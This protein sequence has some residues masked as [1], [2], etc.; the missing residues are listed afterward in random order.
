VKIKIEK[1]VLTSL[2]F[3]SIYV[4]LII[5]MSWDEIIH[6]NNGRNLIRYILSFGKLEYKSLGLPFHFGFYDAFSHFISL[7]FPGKFTIYSHH[8]TNLIFSI[9]AIYGITQFTK[10]LFN[11]EISKIVFLL[12]FFNPIFFG[13]MSVNPKDTIV[14]FSTIWSSVLILKYIKYQHINLKR[15][16][17]MYLIAITLFI[18]VGVR[19]TFI[20]TLLPIIFILLY[21]ITLNKRNNK[22]FNLKILL[23]DL[24]KV[25]L[26]TYIVTIIFWPEMHNNFLKPQEIIVEYFDQLKDGN[27]GLYWGLLNGQIINLSNTPSNY[28]FINFF[29]KMPEFFVISVPLLFIILLFD[30]NF[31]IKKIDNFKKN[32]LYLLLFIVFPI[33]LFI[34]L[35]I[36]VT[37]GL[38]FFLFLVPFLSI[39]PA[40]V[41]YYLF[42]KKNFIS[43][44]LFTSFS[45]LF[46]F[47][48]LIFF[49]IS[50]YQYTYINSLNGK[51]SSNINKFENDY[52][53]LSLKQLIYDF[54][55]KYPIKKDKKY[56][57]AF[58]GVGLDIAEYYLNEIE[59]LTYEKVPNKKKYDFI[60]MTNLLNGDKYDT[61][62]V[63]KSCF[64]EFKGEDLI[65]IE[66][67]DL[68][69]SVLRS[70]KN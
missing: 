27:Y 14:A 67:M 25:F 15:I 1:I 13:H 9:S 11:K 45:F 8:L 48:L 2:I 63:V 22:M 37:V 59:E 50:P 54:Q 41:F 38:K 70:S 32:F 68:K 34:L 65:E 16:K 35:S 28:L 4:S 57:I 46:L 64:N 49:K 29:Y 61:G 56:K 42:K 53:G 44:L 6:Q 69:L 17:Y 47:Y 21:E 51:F 19:L 20:G 31:F 39:I 55:D 40:I 3:Y 60:I 33:I 30:Y 10:I 43:K 7:M 52:W 66:R 23:F 5:G 62:K 36:K 18:G 24:F 12:T 26:I 58:C